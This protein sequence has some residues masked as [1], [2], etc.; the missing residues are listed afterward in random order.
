M[1]KVINGVETTIENVTIYTYEI[2]IRR[3]ESSSMVKVPFC[4]MCLCAAEIKTL[5][6]TFEFNELMKNGRIL[7]EDNLIK[8]YNIS[9]RNWIRS[10]WNSDVI[11]DT[12]NKIN[13]IIDDESNMQGEHNPHLR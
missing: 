7:I 11:Q 5:N 1:K 8:S 12:Y 6:S 13:K 3:S 2:P 10:I 4:P 9:L